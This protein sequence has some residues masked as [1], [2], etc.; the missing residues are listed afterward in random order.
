ML[1]IIFR[2]VEPGACLHPLEWLVVYTLPG[3]FFSIGSTPEWSE[4]LEVLF[5]HN[6]IC[7]LVLFTFVVQLPTLVTGKMSYVDIGWPLGLVVLAVNILRC[8]PGQEGWLFSLISSHPRRLCAGVPLLFHGSRMALG[9]LLQFYPYVFKEDLSRYQYAER[10]WLEHTGGRGKS[11]WWLKQQH[12]TIMQCFANSVQ[13][14]GPCMLMATNPYNHPSGLRPLELAG[15]LLW[16]V[17]F[18]FETV[19]DLQKVTFVSEAKRRGDVRTAVLGQ[20]HYAKYF[21]WAACRHPNYFAEW[22]CW[23]GFCLMALPSVMDLWVHHDERLAAAWA[24]LLLFYCSR[25][26]YD[27][28]VHWTGAS[29]AESRSVKRRGQAYRDYQKSVN[30]IWPINVP[31]FDHHRTPGWPESLSGDVKT[32]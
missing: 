16:I 30:V 18:T 27:C 1:N 11:L 5:Q 24:V 13:L 28:L 29:P 31:F 20:G 9:S 21:L 10:R 3:L 14:A 19:A 12:D 25:T 26:F 22:M 15:L 32:A 17:S 7:Q 8:T 6:F 4:A 23:N 2:L